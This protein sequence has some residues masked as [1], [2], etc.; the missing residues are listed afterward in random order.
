LE[1]KIDIFLKVEMEI[2]IDCLIFIITAVLCLI[3][4]MKAQDKPDAPTFSKVVY[5]VAMGVSTLYALE[6]LL[7]FDLFK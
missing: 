2:S 3:Q 5:G 7:D 6:N 4:F 1:G